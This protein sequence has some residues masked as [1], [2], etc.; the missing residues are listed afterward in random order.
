MNVSKLGKK[1]HLTAGCG[2]FVDITAHAR[3]IV[4]ASFFEAGAR[5]SLDSSGIRVTSA[6]KFAKIVDEVEQVTFCARRARE[7]GMEVVYI[8][9]RCV[10]R[11]NGGG[12]VAIELMPG[13]DPQRDIVEASGNRV[14]IAREVRKM[15]LCLVREEPMGLQ[16]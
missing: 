10:M 4:F 16:L 12:L 5:F 9:E 7:A 2:G 8:T 6:G 14:R 13:I 3:K 1:P 15:P 11:A